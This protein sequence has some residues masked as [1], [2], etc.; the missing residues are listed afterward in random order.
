[1]QHNI[2]LILYIQHYEIDASDM[3]SQGRTF[4]I[5]SRGPNPKIQ[6][7]KHIAPNWEETRL[8]AK[9]IN[10]KVTILIGPPIRRGSWVGAKV[11]YITGHT[12]LEKK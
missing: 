3:Y 10:K 6:K 1:M 2:A 11:V 4:A 9:I 12:G 7:F 8:G 5:G